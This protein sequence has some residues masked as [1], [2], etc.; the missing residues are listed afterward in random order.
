M[1]KLEWSNSYCVGIEIIDSQH[2]KLVELINRLDECDDKEEGPRARELE[3]ILDA[4]LEYTV[5]HFGTEESLMEEYDYE[6]EATE[7]HRLGHQ[8]FI[9]KL[10]ILFKNSRSVEKNGNVLSEFLIKW[11]T[12]HIIDTDKQLADHLLLKGVQL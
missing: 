4:L 8:R 1:A 7:K 11:L 3:M 5:Y 9:Y 10:E 12:F 6:S 2:K